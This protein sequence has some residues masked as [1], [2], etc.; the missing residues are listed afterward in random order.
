MYKIFIVAIIFLAILYSMF[1]VCFTPKMHN[2]ILVYDSAY[3]IVDTHKVETETK[4]LPTRTNQQP[5]EKTVQKQTV[6]KPV[7][8]FFVQK[9][10]KTVTEPVT[11]T[12]KQ[13]TV[14]TTAAEKKTQPVK[15][16]QTQVKKQVQ[17]QVK[18]QVQ[19]QV[20][21]QVQT[22]VKKQVQTTTKQASKPQTKK[23][24]TQ[25]VKKTPAAQTKTAEKQ[26]KTSV[27]IAKEQQ[28]AEQLELIRWNKWRS[29]LQNKIMQDVRLP[30]VPQGTVFK[31][32]FD[33]DKYG[34]VMNIQTWST[35][36]SFTPY[37]IQYIAPVI[38]SYQGKSILN[39]P[40]GS[41]R[42]S[43]TVEGGWKI[44]S[45]TKYSTPADFKDIETVRN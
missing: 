20:K 2:Q 13:Q 36:P 42:I 17:T 4:Q 10:N 34:K 41:N 8:R 9:Q 5:S 11:K 44:S 19:T 12:V 38:R 33:V 3:E 14:K 45:S 18:K 28:E 6:N 37:A 22:Q 24:A 27:Q 30:I 40:E 21:K 23:T 39:F 29:D 32:S 35:N 26:Q 1:V 16:V 25:T 43:T 31:F 7:T 15:Q